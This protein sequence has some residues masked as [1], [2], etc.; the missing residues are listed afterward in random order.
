MSGVYRQRITNAVGV[1]P[2][3]IHPLASRDTAP[4][5]EVGANLFI[6]VHFVVANG[7]RMGERTLQIDI[8]YRQESGIADIDRTEHKGMVGFV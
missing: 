4:E 8:A 6:A 5:I 3:G 7:Q 2:D 1:E